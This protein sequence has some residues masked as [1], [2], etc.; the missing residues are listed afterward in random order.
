MKKIYTP[1]QVQ[2]RIA[3]YIALFV[4]L[5]VGYLWLREVTWQGSKQ[6]HTLMEIVAS[7]LAFL[8][9]AM[10]L[11]RF[12]S[13]KD[14]TFLFI[15][16]GF[17][18]TG[19]LDAYHTIVTSTFFDIYFP[20]PPP[21]LIPW[22]WIASRFFLSLLLWLSWVF[23]QREEKLGEAGKVSERAVYFGTGVLTL[24]SFF[25][26]E[27]VP[28]GFFLLALI[29]YL[30]KGHWKENDFEHW[31]ILSIIVSFM[32]QAMFM[33]FSGHLFDTMFDAAH[34][35]KKVSY[36]GVLIG[37]LLS[38]YTI[39]IRSEKLITES[40]L[41]LN[42]AL[43]TI[44]TSVLMVDNDHKILYFNKAA[45]NLLKKEQNHLRQNLGHFEINQIVGIHI[46]YFYSN[47]QL[48]RQLLGQL[49]G[50]YHSTFQM[51][52]LTID[53]TLTPVIDTNGE[54]LGTVAEFRDIT[55]QVAMEQEINT[56]IHAVSKGDLK[57]GIGLEHKEG[58]LQLISESINT[59]IK[60]NK[61][62]LEDTMRMFALLAKGDLTQTIENDYV[63][64]FE[65]LKNDANATVMKLTEIMTAILQTA[66]AVNTAAEEISQG[67]ISLSQRTSAQATSL[68][69][70][71]AS[72]EQMT[73]T[74]LQNTNNARQATHLAFDAKN[75]AEQGGDVVGS[76]I[77]AMTDIS[78]SSQKI[79]D[80]ITVIN[81][82]AFQTNL[83]AVNAA[84][85]AARAGEHGRGFAVV[86]SEVR[87]LAQ[88]SAAAAKEI[89]GLIED[90]VAKIE[91]GTKLANKSG[92]TLKEIV[93]AV[94]K[95]TEIITEIATAS[96]EQSLGIQQ[97]NRA[98]VQMDERTQKNAALVEE[99]AAASSAM[100]EQ[101]LS[102]KEQVAFFK[103][104]EPQ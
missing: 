50:S 52:S 32:G 35:L 65:Q 59:I 31:L 12:H 21:S 63:G 56:I 101:A 83:L 23:W 6:L 4:A 85:E 73:N 55:L 89:K 97:I 15:G 45:E 30:N 9:G 1:T 14:N 81:E 41:R 71:A 75:F 61:S 88:R 84:V 39:F 8:V 28:A 90:S 24:A 66:A 58:F 51:G 82:I 77:G 95:V 79:T 11:V 38:M 2:K 99:T 44:T 17:L 49:T 29:G 86:A 48:I 91:E 47:P 40:A 74:V 22:S 67:N 26:L 72:M 7:V 34:L 102:L 100:K 93:I 43:D 25:F 69:E 94:T 27:L 37:L 76:T 103:V 104:G 98:I 53:S 10:A 87:N 64:V 96:H 36:I 70:T 33:S 3:T 57:Q 60:L 68:E 46:D 20:S 18:G 16:T 62:L 54:R 5:F 13:K 78:K 80:I 92:K 42:R 19:L